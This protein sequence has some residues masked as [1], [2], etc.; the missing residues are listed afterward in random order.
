LTGKLGAATGGV[1]KK[2]FTQNTGAENEGEGEVGDV[3][4]IPGGR[5]KAEKLRPTEA[6][7]ER[8]PETGRILRVIR[9][10]EEME[11]QGSRRKRRRL[12]DPLNSASSSSESEN[13]NPITD[14]TP[15]DRSQRATGVIAELEAQAEAEAV[16]LARKKRPRQQ[17]K[18]E[19]EWI[20]RLVERYG[21]DF[22][23]MVRD[24]R[25]NP[26]QQTEGDIAR[27]VGRWKGRRDSEAGAGG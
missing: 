21:E 14:P 15:P 24:R 11:G 9:S 13:E 12:D 22:A 10:E 7:V 20:A 2:V 18:R 23:A 17:S 16:L 25:L 8:D 3:F 19:E 1:E 5:R 27:R 26:M 4:A 6:R